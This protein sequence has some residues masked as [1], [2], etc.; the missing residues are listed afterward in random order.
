MSTPPSR[1][2]PPEFLTEVL[3]SARPEPCLRPG[4]STRPHV[5]LTFAQSLDGK[6][7]GKGGKQLIQT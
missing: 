4:D 3:G 7:A 2:Q 1:P 5:T 6:I